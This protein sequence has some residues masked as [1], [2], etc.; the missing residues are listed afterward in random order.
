[1]R[2]PR[3]F[4]DSSNG[5]NIVDASEF[6]DCGFKTFHL[7]VPVRYVYG[8]DPCNLVLFVEL[9]GKCLD[10]FGV[11]VGDEDL[12]ATMLLALGVRGQ[13]G[14]EQTLARPAWLQRRGR[15]RS[16]H[17]DRMFNPSKVDWNSGAYL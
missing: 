15:C 11:L 1:M 3:P 12:D 2:C 17:L 4:T 9:I 10:A 13:Q 7:L 6:G 5:I 8:I 14:N 16:R